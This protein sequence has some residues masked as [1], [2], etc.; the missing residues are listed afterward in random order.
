MFCA[1]NGATAIPRRA[2]A[3]HKP[4]TTSDLPASDD[5]P[6]ISTPLDSAVLLPTGAVYGVSAQRSDACRI[7]I[8]C[9]WLCLCRYQVVTCSGVV[10]RDGGTVTGI[11]LRI[12]SASA[13]VVVSS[14]VVGA[15]IYGGT[16]IS[17]PGA[18]NRGDRLIAVPA[19]PSPS[20]ADTPSETPL[21]TPSASLQATP[22]GASQTHQA[23]PLPRP[24]NCNIHQSGSACYRPLKSH[25]PAT[26]IARSTHSPSTASTPKRRSTAEQT[27]HAKTTAT[28]KPTSAAK[29][30]P[31][32]KASSSPSGYDTRSDWADAVLD[33]LNSERAAH[34]LSALKLNSKLV[35]SAHTHNLAMAKADTLSHKLN[36]EAELGSRVS[37]AGYDWSMVGENIA[38]NSSRTESGVLAVQKAMYNEKPP[39]DGHRQNILN[40]R[41]VDVGIDVIN[42]S[43]HGKVWLVTDFGRP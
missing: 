12:A 31:S 1:L 23:R 35:D 10:V 11:G 5:V 24:Q 32:T 20:P 28:K 4:V 2:K 15:A 34:G 40:K 33:E 9:V 30:A 19:A 27:H 39:N 14:A 42:D 17:D 22:S 3:R 25:G 21:A 43:E 13:A 8:I 7:R 41:F 26:P 18:P 16:A 6:A 38:Y 29:S 36:G 37:A